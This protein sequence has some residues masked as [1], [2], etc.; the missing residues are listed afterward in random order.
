MVWAQRHDGTEFPVD[1]SISRQG[2]SQGWL[3]TVFLRDITERY[4]AEQALAQSET[5]LRRVN[6]VLSVLSGINTL[7]VRAADPGELLQK[8]CDIAVELGQF[9]RAWIGLLDDAQG[10][11][12]L[13]ASAGMDPDTRSDVERQLADPALI[14]GDWGVSLRALQPVVF[15]AMLTQHPLLAAAAAGGTQSL[16]ML[17]LARADQLVGVLV[18]HASEPGFFDDE[19]VKLL[20]E[21]A[22]DIAYALDH[23]GNAERLRFLASY[24]ALTG[25]PNRALFSDYLA[26]ALRP[27]AGNGERMAV[28]LVDIERFRRVNETFGRDAGDDLLRQIGTRLHAYNDTVARLGVDVFAIKLTGAVSAEEI[29]HQFNRMR[30]ACFAAP[31]RVADESLRIGCRAGVAIFPADGGDPEALLRNAEASLRRA[32]SSSEALVFYAPELNARAAEAMSLESKLRRAIDQQEFVLHYQP[33][34][35]MLDRR[36]TGVEALIRWQDPDQGLVPP[37]K[38]IPVLEECG[39]IGEVGRWALQ[40]ALRDQAAW[41]NQ[42]VSAPRVAVNVSPLQLRRHDFADDIVALVDG[43]ALNE[44]ELEITESV[45]MDNVERNIAAL[46]KVRAAGVTVAVDDFGTGYCSLSYI[47][48]LPVTSL[49][50]DR[51]FIVGMTSGPEGLAIVSSIIALAHALRLKVVAEGVETEDQ[52]RL[53]HLLGCDEAQGYLFC[54]PVPAD[55]ITVLLKAKGPLPAS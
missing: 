26:R 23:L 45:I 36:I 11:L 6:R 42:G 28:M 52:A 37:G 32:R 53:L 25:L 17:P 40:Q 35:A 33:K 8:S 27:R 48:K 12:R 29:V 31:C 13:A 43:K 24:D 18:L 54:R 9:P 50:I 55:A 38:F 47:A 30:E 21:L 16:A 2:T 10:P 3:Y 22:S 51:A 20:S 49:K 34:V 1:A 4:Q 39:L 19:E 41:W 7:I 5:R 46:A 14:P 15:N 44:L